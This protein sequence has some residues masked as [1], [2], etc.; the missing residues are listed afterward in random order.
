MTRGIPVESGEEFQEEINEAAEK[1]IEDIEYGKIEVDADFE[2]VLRKL[3][4][5][6]I[7]AIQYML[8]DDANLIST[9]LIK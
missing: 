7:L 6:E 9:P 3:S 2:M 5:V 1:F 8:I 4:G